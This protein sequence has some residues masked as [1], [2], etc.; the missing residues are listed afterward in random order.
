MHTKKYK[1]TI[2]YML[3]C[4]VLSDGL[5]LAA[6][7]H[8]LGAAVGPPALDHRQSLHQQGLRPHRGGVRG[9]GQPEILQKL[10]RKTI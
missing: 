7:I 5:Q 4:Q 6:Q 9:L 2:D 10:C 8:I 3:H 1:H